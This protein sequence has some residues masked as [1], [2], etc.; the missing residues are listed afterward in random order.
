MPA[1]PAIQHP[2]VLG[3]VQVVPPQGLAALR[4]LHLDRTRA[5]AVTWQLTK[6]DTQ[7]RSAQSKCPR[8]QGNPAPW[9]MRIAVGS[10]ERG[11]CGSACRPV[12]S[13]VVAGRLPL[14]DE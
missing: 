11:H 14:L 8:F 4:G 2:P 13:S 6:Q 1:S 7:A 12:H 3:P 10:A 5:P 9:P